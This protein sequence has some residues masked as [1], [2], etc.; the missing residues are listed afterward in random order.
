[1]LIFIILCFMK[2]VCTEKIYG[3]NRRYKLPIHYQILTIDTNLRNK[4]LLN[5]TRHN[6][7]VLMIDKDIIWQN[8]EHVE[9]C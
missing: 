7:R 6:L 1:M 9:C 2:V 3:I 4:Y 8:S 5:L